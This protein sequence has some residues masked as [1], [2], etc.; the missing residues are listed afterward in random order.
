MKEKVIS[1]EESERQP[2]L[3]FSLYEGAGLAALAGE[4]ILDDTSF[5][6]AGLTNTL[7]TTFSRIKFVYSGH[8]VF[9]L[10]FDTFADVDASLG[11]VGG[12]AVVI[13]GEIFVGEDCFCEFDINAD[14]AAH[15]YIDGQVVVKDVGNGTF[16]HSYTDYSS[17]NAGQS[18]ATGGINLTR[19]YH[20]ITFVYVDSGADDAAILSWR[21]SS[22]DSF[23]PVPAEAFSH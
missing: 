17:P 2:G 20:D 5:Q 4:A 14:D 3:E 1:S 7:N 11:T 8:T 18:L 15:L 19:G 12:F 22:S 9:M 23:V 6:A 21:K 13:K 10:D 16:N